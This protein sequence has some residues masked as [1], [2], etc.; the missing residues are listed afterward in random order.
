MQ[1]REDARDR[2]SKYRDMNKQLDDPA[3]QRL[4]LVLIWLDEKK[5]TPTTVQVQPPTTNITLV[6]ELCESR[7]G[8]PGLSV[9]TSL[10][11]SV[12]VKIYWTMLRHWSQLVP[13]ICQPTS[14]DIKHHF[15][16]MFCC[17]KVHVCNQMCTFS[18]PKN[19]DL[20]L[21][22]FILMET[23]WTK[24][25]LI[26]AAIKYLNKLLTWGFRYHLQ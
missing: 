23:F 18:A 25:S 11:A 10:P 4:L 2:K 5:A 21:N 8:R 15:I 6:Q 24:L 20:Q 19:T 9:L 14:E 13:N 1:Q 3:T 7:G 12:D 16:I 22:S 17:C 26:V